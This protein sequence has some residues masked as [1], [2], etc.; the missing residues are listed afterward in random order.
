MTIKNYH[1]FKGLSTHICNNNCTGVKVEIEGPCGLGLGIQPQG[2]HV[3]FAA[4][5]G[6]LVFI[7]LVAH[8]IIRLIGLRANFAEPKIDLDN[9]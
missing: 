4:G 8:L 5:T 2:R 6:I 3:A 1:D 9:F 7:D